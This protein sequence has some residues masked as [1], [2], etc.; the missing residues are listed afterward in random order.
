MPLDNPQR[1][2]SDFVTREGIE[3]MILQALQPIQSELQAIK[4]HGQSLYGNGSGKPGKLEEMEEKQDERWNEQNDW[5][6]EVN[7]KLNGVTSL[8]ASKTAVAKDRRW[9][10]AQVLTALLILGDLW[11]RAH[12]K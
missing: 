4:A 1:R 3:L 7:R 12:G 9:I 5:K 2:G 11:A 6:E 8:L 10:I